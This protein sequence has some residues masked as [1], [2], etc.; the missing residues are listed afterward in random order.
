MG[1]VPLP[2]RRCATTVDGRDD[3]DLGH[4]GGHGRGGGIGRLRDERRV[5]LADGALDGGHV[6]LRGVRRRGD[7]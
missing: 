3:H 7:G 2:P 6:L 4:L 5:D 1:T